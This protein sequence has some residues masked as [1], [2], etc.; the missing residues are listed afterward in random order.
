MAARHD[1]PCYIDG[2][3]VVTCGP[4]RPG[5]EPVDDA[6][7]GGS[8]DDLQLVI[9]N[10]DDVGRGC[11]SDA[12]AP[13]GLH[14]DCVCDGASISEDVAEAACNTLTETCSGISVFTAR[15][16]ASRVCDDFAMYACQPEAFYRV[17]S[18]PDCADEF[19]K[20]G[21]MCTKEEAMKLVVQTIDKLCSPVC[22]DCFRL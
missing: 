6:G 11:Q 7:V 20:G 18:N 12:D 22:E 17:L 1:A 21:E 8:L 19:Q 10:E 16:N 3:G 2:C 4:P 5:C 13:I 14:E 9:V 15:R